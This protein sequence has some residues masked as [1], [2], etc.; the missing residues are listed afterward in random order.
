VCFENN[1]LALSCP[2]KVAE[3]AHFDGAAHGV[4]I[5]GSLVGH[6]HITP[7]SASGNRPFDLIPFECSLSL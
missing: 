1:L 6:R 2:I 3:V 7:G 4:A 5:N